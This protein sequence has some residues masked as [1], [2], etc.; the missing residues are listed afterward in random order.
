MFLLFVVNVAE[1][2]R[3]RFCENIGELIANKG[4]NN[5]LFTY[6]HYA[7]LIMKVKE[8][9]SKTSYK[10]PTD[11]KRLA[12]YDVIQIGNSQ[13]LIVPVK[14]CSMP[15][16]YFAYL[17]ETFQIIHDCHLTIGHGGRVRMM[18][19][20]KSKYKNVTAELVMVYLNLCEYCTRKKNLLKKGPVAGDADCHLSWKLGKYQV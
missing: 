8:A 19:V 20:L 4:K 10:T 3:I 5:Q 16:I 12:R 13:K 15:I 2:M 18:K 1:T 7:W 17:E 11:Y 6:E 14:D 9:K